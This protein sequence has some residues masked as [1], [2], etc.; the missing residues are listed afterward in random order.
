MLR[1]HLNY[2]SPSP[3]TRYSGGG[4]YPNLFDAH[5][6]FQIDG[7]FG[8]TA[9]IAEML[10]QSQNGEIQLL[11]ALPDVWREG[12]IKGLRARGGFTVDQ[13]WKNGKLTKS[14]IYPDHDSDIRIRYAGKTIS[15]KGN[16][17]KQVEVNSSMFN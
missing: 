15:V 4:T 2:V 3:D 16:S 6:P 11:P 9:G 10:L 12:Y 1:T 7:N 14:V 13:F 5:P 17:G 8:G